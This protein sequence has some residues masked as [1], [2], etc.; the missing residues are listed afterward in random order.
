ML[1]QARSVAGGAGHTIVLREDGTVWSVGR[2]T[3]GQL[4]DGTLTERHTPEAIPG[5]DAVVAV[6]AAEFDS[7]ALRTDGTLWSWG[8]SMG[9]VL[10]YP[11]AGDVR[12]PRQIPGL[13]GVSRFD[14]GSVASAA[15]ITNE[16]VWT[17]GMDTG[18]PDRPISREP[19][20]LPG[21]AGATDVARGLTHGLMLLDGAPRPPP[22][23]LPPPVATTLAVDAPAAAQPGEPVIFTATVTPTP[24]GGTVTLSTDGLEIARGPVDPATGV[25]TLTAV[26]LS[27]RT[28][29]ILADFPAISGFEGSSVAFDLKVGRT[30]TTTKV[31]S[32]SPPNPVERGSP[33]TIA[34]SVE[35][36]PDQPAELDVLVDSTWV[37]RVPVESEVTVIT[38]DAL[39]PGTHVV[40][41]QFVG[42]DNY[43]PSESAPYSVIVSG[44]PTTTSLGATPADRALAGTPITFEVAVEPAGAAGT[45]DIVDGETTIGTIDLAIG[46]TFTTSELA[47]GIYSIH[48]RFIPSG[49]E[50]EPSVSAALSYEVYLDTTPPSGTV[51]IDDEGGYWPSLTVPLTFSATDEG[52]AG[53]AFVEVS[54]DGA[55]WERR[56]WPLEETWSWSLTTDAMAPDGVYTVYARFGDAAGNISAVATDSTFLDRTLPELSG[57]VTSRVTVGAQ[58]TTSGA[59]PVTVQWPAGTDAG[60]G[61]AA[62]VVERSLDGGAWIEWR[63]VPPPLGGGTV[64][65]EDLV[66]ADSTRYRVRAFDVFGRASATIAG[67]RMAFSRYQEASPE[68]GTTGTW[69]SNAAAEAWGGTT[70][71][72]TDTGATMRLRF[73]GRGIYWI[74][75]QGAL[76]GRADVYID[77]KLVGSVDLGQ[78]GVDRTVVFGHTFSETGN[79]TIRIRCMGTP[80]RPLVESD[81]FVAARW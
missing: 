51:A 61:V 39:S 38:L 77:S 49:P 65:T 44:V 32:A 26:F 37:A 29:S 50:F 43:A 81:G 28:Y 58:M 16:G 24:D 67:S 52:G 60:S 54:G 76:R 41:A 78:A 66:G 46:H 59:V 47:A 73:T 57:T 72:A 35:P 13:S 79:H 18:N 12:S 9:D 31:V 36:I 14:L 55:A 3:D 71:S 19:L 34:V 22:P 15:A 23:I 56:P 33:V 21:T 20:L 53:V 75:P 27:E 25:A 17:W 70:S 80:D 63:T 45:V 62:Y 48:A 10:G 6:D 7:M 68:V 42:N 1:D 4:G 40:I 74:A 30:P 2:N 8:D 64:Q 5:F 11:T 69:Q